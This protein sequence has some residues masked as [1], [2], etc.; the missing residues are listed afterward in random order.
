MEYKIS[1]Q[2]L[3]EEEKS[4][5]ADKI[6]SIRIKKQKLEQE[7]KEVEKLIEDIKDLKKTNY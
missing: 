2:N 4:F 1:E 6:V 3:S 5:F 7:I